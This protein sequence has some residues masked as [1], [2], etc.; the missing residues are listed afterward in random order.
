MI[1]TNTIHLATQFCVSCTTN[2]SQTIL[3]AN[4]ITI[5]VICYALVNKAIVSPHDFLTF[6]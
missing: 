4:K 5:E 2:Q 1:D 6:I 3:L